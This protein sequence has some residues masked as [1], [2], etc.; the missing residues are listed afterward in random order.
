MSRIS[1]VAAA[2]AAAALLA[3]AGASTAATPAGPP[4]GTQSDAQFAASNAAVATTDVTA[5]KRSCYT[6]EVAYFGA[7]APADGYPDGGSTTCAAP[8]TG[9]DVGPYP[10]QN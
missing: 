9:E 7:L 5:L 4:Q 1:L 6:P 8:T 3:L 2:L 10:T